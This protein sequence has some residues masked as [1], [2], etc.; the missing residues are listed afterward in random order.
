MCEGKSILRAENGRERVDW[1]RGGKRKE[2][3][4]KKNGKEKHGF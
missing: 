3:E 2:E 1:R 4:K